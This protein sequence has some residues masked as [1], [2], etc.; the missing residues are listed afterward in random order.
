[1]S[2]ISSALSRILRSARVYVGVATNA[3]SSLGNF[4]LSIALAGTLAIN[5]LGEFAVAFALYAF[6]TGLIRAGVCE[7]LLATTLTIRDLKTAAGRVSML[8]AFSALALVI[9]GVV[10]DM[11]YLLVTAASIHGLSLYDFS[12]TMNISAFDRRIALAQEFIWFL[13]ALTAGVLIHFG[14]VSGLVGYTIWAVSG[15]LTGYLSSWMQKYIVKPTWQLSESET[16]NS[17]AFGGDFLIGSGASQVA[18]NLIG[19]VAGLSAVGSLRA[20]GTLLGP[21]SIIV[22][23]ARSLAI[24]Y[25]SRGIM[26][27]STDALSRSF[28][29]TLIMGI[30]TIPFLGLIAFL[31]DA[32]GK[33]L[34]GENWSYAEPVLPFLALEMAFIALT[35]IPFAGFRA[36]LAGRATII[37]RSAL[38]VFRVVLVVSAAIAGGAMASAVAMAA[39]S[40]IGMLV[41]WL[42]YF[43][44]L[45]NK[46]K[47]TV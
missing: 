30:T 44:Q 35:T 17:A 39:A 33:S 19:V 21:V 43:L 14:I 26:R 46:T 12:K 25:L 31:P 3:L 42:G 11:P 47:E 23:S 8:S 10:G 16:R 5:E 28:A 18:F 20:G 32:L 37:I 45:R 22:S 38:A 4:A 40:G 24:P 2:E 34:L 41:W 9:A 15:A 6:F 13:F 27:G 1:M 29:S 7:P 36:L